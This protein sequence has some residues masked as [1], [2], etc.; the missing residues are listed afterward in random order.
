MRPLKVKGFILTCLLIFPL[1]AK[2]QMIDKSGKLDS[3]TI[4]ERIALRTNSVDWLLLVPNISAEFDLGKYNWNP[5]SVIVGVKGN[6][7]TS[8]SFKPAQVYNLAGVRGEVRQYWRTRKINYNKQ[9]STTVTSVM[10]AKNILQRLFSTNRYTLKHPNTTYYRGIYA[11]Y[12]KYSILLGKKGKQGAAISAGLSYGIIQPLYEFKSGNSL[13][14]EFGVSAGLCFT[15]YDEYRHDRESDCYPRLATK[16]WHI[17]PYPMLSEARVA[18]VYRFGS[19]PMTNKYHWRYDVDEK[20]RKEKDAKLAVKSAEL[21]NKMD[22]DELR[23]KFDELYNQYYPAQ[24][25]KAD[26]QVEQQRREDE[27][28]AQQKKDAAAKVVA[29]KKAAADAAKQKK[30]DEKAAAQQ[31]KAEE[32]AAKQ[33]KS[34]EVEEKPEEQTLPAEEPST[35]EQPAE[36][37]PAEDT[38][39]E[40][41]STEEQPT[42]DTPTEEP[43]TEE[44]PTEEKTVEETEEGGEA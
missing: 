11:A 30:A 21:K 9:D 8:H 17:L 7:Q 18:F 37:T 10:P 44:A 1:L 29:D 28:A 22:M 27:K 19:H 3:L 24:K 32:K 41:P 6:W 20:Y 16:G 34:E 35:E 25:E 38:P 12:D 23:K 4:A 14:L 43:S 5:Y 13:D 31:K 33:K 26:K 15:K 40:E 36:E 42:E 2:A 39:T